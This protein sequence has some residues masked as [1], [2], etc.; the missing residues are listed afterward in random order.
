[1]G[2][3]VSVY[4]SLEYVVVFGTNDESAQSIDNAALPMDHLFM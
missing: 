1:M 4:M 3:G 2:Y